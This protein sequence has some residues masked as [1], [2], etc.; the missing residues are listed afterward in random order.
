MGLYT[1]AIQKLYV[2]YFNRPA[3]AAGLQYWETVAAS[4]N[5]ELTQISSAFSKSAEYIAAYAGKTSAEVVSQVYSNLFGRTAEPGGLAYWAPLLNRGAITVD[6]VVTAVAGGALGADAVAY[7]QKVNAATVFTNNLNTPERNESYNGDAALSVAKAFIATVRNI[8]TYNQAISSANLNNYFNQLNTAYK[9]G[10]SLFLGTDI[11]TIAPSGSNTLATKDNFYA[12][13]ITFNPGDKIDGGAESDKLTLISNN[14]QPYTVPTNVSVNN[15]ETALT[16]SDSIVNINTNSWNG[17]TLLTVDS[18]GGANV[19]V[20]SATGVR[21]NDGLGAGSITL[22]GG[23]S[24]LVNAVKTTTGSIN[25]G[26]TEPAAKI[27]SVFSHIAEGNQAGTITVNGGTEV[28]ITQYVDSA[29]NTTRLGAIMVNANAATSKVDINNTARDNDSINNSIANT[30]QIN[31][32]G[33]VGNLK[34]VTVAKFSNLT[35]TGNALT[36]LTLKSGKADA[37]LIGNQTNVHV[38]LEDITGGT[39][40]VDDSLQTLNLESYFSNTLD[41]IVG[42]SLN[43]IDV[44]GNGPLTLKPIFGLKNLV[45]HD[46]EVRANFEQW[47]LENLDSSHEQFTGNRKYTIDGSKTNFI[48]GVDSSTITLTN[49]AINKHIALGAGNDTLTLQGTALSPEARLEGG[50]GYDQLAVSVKNVNQLLTNPAFSGSVTGFEGLVLTDA[51]STGINQVVDASKLT[52]FS[53]I[54]ASGGDRL[55]LNNWGNNQTLTLNGNGK[56]YV[57][58]NPGFASGNND[59]LNLTLTGDAGRSY[60]YATEGVFAPDVEKISIST[61]N[62]YNKST[63]SL[64]D[65]SAQEITLQG[66]ANLSLTVNDTALTLLDASRY[67]GPFS[68]T[69]AQVLNPLTVLASPEGGEFDF[70]SAKSGVT[71]IG[72]SGTDKITVGAGIN[73]ITVGSGAGPDMIVLASKGASLDSFTTITDVHRLI[74]IQF[75]DQGEEIFH[76][77][78]VVLDNGASLQDYANEV[79][80]QAGNAAVNGV[81]GWFQFANATYIVESRHNGTGSDDHFINGTDML[82]KLAGN[83]DP[84]GLAL[85]SGGLI[86]VY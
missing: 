17:L 16:V 41:G 46:V 6:S 60:A 73:T 23:S 67:Q 80:H 28:R 49:T 55:T 66:S 33:A 21:I 79:I 15:V 57:I 44:T 22:N 75:P 51:A 13:S 47:S 64:S 11:D 63:L 9:L 12:T 18:Q 37:K 19:R 76:A 34:T 40:R 81:F 32:A 36:D 38:R 50:A 42:K 5:G 65:N 7:A 2:A 53:D 70:H 86:Q 27:V 62:N 39:L 8:D 85:F 74:S 3:D 45:L 25:I 72:R 56:S 83:T 48:G 14:G 31:D 59:T 58:Q 20:G 52:G 43:T 29:A 69:A 35:V 1:Q 68:V 30:V 71:F 4:Q 77:N 54:I 26:S 61:G 78:R 24:V 84:I 10:K 82:V